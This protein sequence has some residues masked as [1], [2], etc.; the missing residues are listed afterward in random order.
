MPFTVVDVGL[1][2]AFFPFLILRKLTRAKYYVSEEDVH[3]YEHAI[4]VQL[5]EDKKMAFNEKCLILENHLEA[6]SYESELKIE[7][8]EEEK[9]RLENKLNNLEE[10]NR[11]LRK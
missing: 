7:V 2:M 6:T 8:L 10:E 11:L 1:A 4:N 3:E 5:L 9:K